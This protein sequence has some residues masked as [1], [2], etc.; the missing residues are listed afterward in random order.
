MSLNG[1]YFFHKWVLFCILVNT[2]SAPLFHDESVF[3]GSIVHRSFW[4]L[5]FSQ[6][7]MK[8]TQVL[9]CWTVKSAPRPPLHSPHCTLRERSPWEKGSHSGLEV[10][11]DHFASNVLQ[12]DSRPRI[13]DLVSFSHFFPLTHCMREQCLWQTLRTVRVMVST[14]TLRWLKHL[15]AFTVFYP[16]QDCLSKAGV[17]RYLKT[18]GLHTEGWKELQKNSNFFAKGDQMGC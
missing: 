12:G 13:L 14:T 7:A 17:A 10:E 4:K 15:R 11:I 8:Q 6:Q 5:L 2:S 18:L 3:G 16:S 9:Q 1:A